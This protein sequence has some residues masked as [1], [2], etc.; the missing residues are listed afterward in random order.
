[1]FLYIE[2]LVSYFKQ[3]EVP[4]IELTVLADQENEVLDMVSTAEVIC[5]IK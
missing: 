5:Q 3:V 1:M 2:G 4:L